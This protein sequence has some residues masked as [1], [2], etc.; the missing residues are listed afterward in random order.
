MMPHRLGSDLGQFVGLAVE[1][2]A[3]S[4]MD[5]NSPY[6]DNGHTV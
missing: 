2:M 3:L 4:A 1:N 5:P 6:G